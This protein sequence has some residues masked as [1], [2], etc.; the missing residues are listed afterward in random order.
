MSQHTKNYSHCFGGLSKNVLNR[1]WKC[2]QDCF[3]PES[4]CPFSGPS[5]IISGRVLK[6]QAEVCLANLG[7]SQSNVVDKIKYLSVRAKKEKDCPII[8]N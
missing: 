2:G 5:L 1:K 8:L 4:N 7:V 6:A 3:F